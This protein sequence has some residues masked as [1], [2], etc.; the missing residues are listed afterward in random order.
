LDEYGPSTSWT[1]QGRYRGI[2]SAEDIED[3][4]ADGILRLWS[5]RDLY[6][7]DRISL[8]RWFYLLTQRAAVNQLRR[9]PPSTKKMSLESIPDSTLVD[10][11]P[12]DSSDSRA[13]CDLDEILGALPPD[14]R[15]I[16]LARAE[17]GG[18]WT[19]A[20]ADI[21]GQNPDALRVRG[22]R[23]EERIRKAMRERGHP[24]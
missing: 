23:I 2:L 10:T 7:P 22:H 17:S 13:R 15:V 16:V 3:A 1:L 24:V 14:D 5:K 21:L 18:R 4:L 9:K 11:R 19:R 12:E 20:L 8:R 6:D